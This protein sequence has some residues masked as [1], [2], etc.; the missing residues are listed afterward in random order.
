M[1]NNKNTFIAI[2]LMLGVWVLFT[3]LFPPAQ[4]QPP[5][6]PQTQPVAEQS[7]STQPASPTVQQM[8]T[9]PAVIPVIPTEEKELVIRTD[10]FSAVFTNIGARLKH[11]EL[12]NYRVEDN[13]D[14]D[15]VSVI[16][17]D[18]PHLATL[19]LAGVNGLLLSSEAPYSL[20]DGGQE[21]SLVG[22]D[23][24]SFVFS[25]TTSDGVVIE[26]VFTFYGN[27]YAVDVDVR[28]SN[29]GNKAVRGGL[30]LSL[31]E[32]FDD[33]VEPEQF[34]FVG[35]ATYIDGELKT[36]TLED[37][38]E[39]SASFGKSAIWS[40]YEDK[41]FM[42]ALV[43]LNGASEKVRMQRQD[44]MVENIFNL[45]FLS[46]NPGMTTSQSFMAYFGPRDK[47]I[48]ESV[49][50][51]L[52]K[53]IDF[54]FFSPISEPLL[55]FMNKINTY[56]HNY[57]IAIILVTVVIKLL[58][59]PLT[60]KSYASMKAMQKLAPEIQKLKDRFKNDRA[61]QGQETMALYKENRV[62]PMSGC[63][64]MLIQIPVFFAL[65]R[66]LYEAIE[67]RHADFAFWI[68]DLSAKDPYY[69]TPLVMGATMFIQQKM[70]PSTMDKT[71]QK[72]FLMMPVVFTVMFL[73]FPSGLVIYW[74]INNLL[75]IAQQYYIHRKFA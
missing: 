33:T 36:E 63:L 70:T 19:R 30:E 13:V 1:D 65:Y 43:P 74:L 41:Y 2:G 5:V 18:F 6:E 75:T 44:N 55:W 45:P 20:P 31:V 59:W 69:I 28:V 50:H 71:Q 34:S 56:I 17:V 53:A 7:V 29:P 22:D 9:Q 62:N 54:G 10:L 47:S 73:N 15:L 57:G 48:L 58:F 66:V 24:K 51:D 61:R 38:K 64:P 21:V 39:K 68:T 67:L 3:I 37:L 16:D 4:N 32:I 52:S 14:A 23:K 49:N 72:I 11:L 40:A 25:T 27:S 35:A 26:K 42:S 8:T 46:L 60:H 12:N